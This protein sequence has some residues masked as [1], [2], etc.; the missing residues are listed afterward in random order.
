[1]SSV[2]QLVAGLTASGPDFKKYL[3]GTKNPLSYAAGLVSPANELMRASVGHYL[4]PFLNLHGRSVASHLAKIQ[5]AKNTDSDPDGGRIVARQAV[6]AVLA[7]RDNKK[8]EAERPLRA[9]DNVRNM[10][11]MCLGKDAADFIGR[12][13]TSDK[14]VDAAVKLVKAEIKAGSLTTGD[15]DDE[16]LR[17]MLCLIDEE[18][19]RKAREERMLLDGALKRLGK[20]SAPAQEP[21]R[22]PVPVPV[23]APLPPLPEHTRRP[24]ES[25]EDFLNPDIPNLEPPRPK[26]PK[27]DACRR[28]MQGAETIPHRVRDQNLNINTRLG[29]GVPRRAPGEVEMV[30]IRR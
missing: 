17:Q 23:R 8:A 21:E 15:A 16:I 19:A 1:M 7:A 2:N 9:M 24:S 18:E 10:V 20:K 5:F 3:E 29:A 27:S 12:L 22:A 28:N 30:P 14:E 4:H 25:L 6:E 11:Q 13:T 26:T